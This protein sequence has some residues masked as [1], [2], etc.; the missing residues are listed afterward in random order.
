MGFDAGDAL[1]MGCWVVI[2]SFAALSDLR[3]MAG[4]VA[5]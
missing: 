4:L 1:M 5:G 3:G 2:Q